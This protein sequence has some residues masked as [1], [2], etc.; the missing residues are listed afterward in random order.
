[1]SRFEENLAWLLIGGGLDYLLDD[2]DLSLIDLVAQI[3]PKTEQSVEWYVGR[4]IN[5]ALSP[6]IDSPL[7]FRE[8]LRSTRSIISGSLALQVALAASWSCDGMDIYIPEG[9]ARDTVIRY[10][11]QEEWYTVVQPGGANTSGR[12]PRG[13]YITSTTL[14]ERKIRTLQGETIRKINIIQSSDD[15]TK[16]VSSFSTTWCMNW[17]ASDEIIVLYPEMTLAYEG[18][19]N[20]PQEVETDEQAIWL[21]KYISRGFKLVDGADI[22]T[23]APWPCTS[24]CSIRRAMDEGQ[25]ASG[26]VSSTYRR[27]HSPEE[28]WVQRGWRSLSDLEYTC[29]DHNEPPQAPPNYVARYNY[30]HARYRSEETDDYYI[31]LPWW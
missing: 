21:S 24:I 31:A 3:T 27:N 6:W 11:C 17:I 14:L 1:M 18:V 20:S 4:R 9:E 10:L 19:L 12:R 22:R 29:V 26:V 7:E 28:T 2:E 5:K 30:Y 16:P 15:A 13:E 8:L 23:S 25:D